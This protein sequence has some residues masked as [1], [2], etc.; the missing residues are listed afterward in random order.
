MRPPQGIV[1]SI[2]Q[3]FFKDFDYRYYLIFILAS[4]DFI[5]IS[6]SKFLINLITFFKI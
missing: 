6:Y 3:R 2:N 4:N 5:S 1:I